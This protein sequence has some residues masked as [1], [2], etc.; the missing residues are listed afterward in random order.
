MR[1]PPLK[2][3][4]KHFSKK[5]KGDRL[6]T[7]DYTVIAYYL[8]TPIEEPHLEVKKQKVFCENRDMKGR[9]YI[10]EEGIN[11]QLSGSKKDAEAYMKWIKLDP[12]FKEAE[13]K[14]HPDSRNVFSKMTIKYRKEIVAVGEDV[15]VKKTGEHLDALAWDKMLDERDDDTIVIDTRNDYEWK[16]GHFEG[17][18][19]PNL[20]TFREFPKYARDL[21]KE[22]DPKKT[23]VMMYCTGGIRCELYSALMKEEGFENVYQL[24][25][26]VIKYGLDKHAKNWRGKL[27]VFDDRMV[28]PISGSDNE[29]ISECHY[30]KTKTDY[31][32]NC[33]NMDCNELIIACKECYTSHKGC[34]S[35]TCLEGRVRPIQDGDHNTPFRKLPFEEKQKLN[36]RLG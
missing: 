11:G 23:K 32:Y 26:G 2:C 36:S 5:V 18:D 24:D 21:K 3:K 16:V 4:W 19:L 9:I 12:R 29:T 15:D 17:A 10:S 33:A 34:C 25:G 28:V 14:L 1:S 13:F 27:F 20:K 22:R 6:S 7:M 30:C 31:Y 35:K 8:F